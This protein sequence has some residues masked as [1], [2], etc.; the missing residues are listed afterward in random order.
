M[1]ACRQEV[2]EKSSLLIS[3]T[4]RLSSASLIISDSR[5]IASSI[6][7]LPMIFD[8]SEKDAGSELKAYMK[9]V[10]SGIE[11]VVVFN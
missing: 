8:A 10:K 5:K 4:S 6:F 1:N 11:H 3:K 2:E 9:S 7:M